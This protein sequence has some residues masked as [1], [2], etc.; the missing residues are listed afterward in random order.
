MKHQSLFDDIEK[1]LTWLSV[2]IT[3]RNALNLHDLNI[4]CE[5][6]YTYLLNLL[7]GWDLRNANTNEQNIKAIDLISPNQKILVQVSSTNTAS[8]IQDSLN[9]LD[10]KYSGYRFKFISIAKSAEKL[11]RRKFSVPAYIL[12]D[13]STD[14]LDIEV[15]LR[16]IQSLPLAKM[17]E[18][19]EFI[20]KE[21]PAET[22]EL[23]LETGLAYVINE[24]SKIDL[25][26]DRS[27]FDTTSYDIEKKIEKNNLI[28][29]KNIIEQ[30]NI[31]FSTVQKIYDEYD[32]MGKNK[33][34]AVLQ[35]INKEYLEQK[36]LYSGDPLY[37]VISQKIKQK[38]LS[39]ANLQK[40]YDEDLNLYIDIILVDAFIRCK[41]FE[42]P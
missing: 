22:N 40:F 16:Q 20:K 7:Y 32:L 36:K 5:S 4:H 39:S 8:K 30:Y 34:Y 29:F 17:E 38:L 10:K 37:E 2:R 28:S 15:L 9:K 41:I 25:E 11:M 19:C 14:I 35:T 1:R 13:S 27:E 42:K 3:T 23:K 6:F 12:F 31:H 18:V 26:N 33:S 24:L 21:F